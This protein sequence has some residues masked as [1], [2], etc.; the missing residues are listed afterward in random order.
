MIVGNGWILSI[1]VDVGLTAAIC[2]A[3]LDAVFAI[4]SL[5]SCVTKAS[6]VSQQS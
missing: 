5:K 6:F 1:I 2:S 3:M 4:E